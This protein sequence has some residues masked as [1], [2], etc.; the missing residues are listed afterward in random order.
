M[1]SP[2]ERWQLASAHFERLADAGSQ[3]K[4]AALAELERS[5]PDL[6]Q[7]LAQMLHGDTT[8]EGLLDGGLRRIAPTVVE[9]LESAQTGQAA[10][11]ALPDI[12]GLRVIE[13]IGSG[14]MG[15]V[16]L[17]ERGSGEFAQ[18][19]ALKLL[20]AGVDSPA[21]RRRFSHER[22]ILAALEH[23]D[24]ARFIDGGV[25]ADGRPWFA[26]E[27]V[28]GESISEYARRHRLGLRQRVTLMVQVCRAVAYAQSRLVVHRDLK[29]SNIL[30]D[31]SGRPRLLDFGIAKLLEQEPGPEAETELRAMSPAYAAPEQLLDQPVSTATDV[32]ALGVVLHELITGCLPRAAAVSQEAALARAREDLRTAP[33]ARLREAAEEATVELGLDR[34][35]VFRLAREARGDLDLILLTALRADPRRRYDG[36]AALAEDLQRWL[37][38]RPI[39]ARPD[40]AG[41]RFRRFVGRH[42]LGVATAALVL[43]SLLA[44]LSAALWQARRADAEAMRAT[45]AAERAERSR[46]FFA[47]LF[48]DASPVRQNKGAQMSLAEFVAEAAQRVETELVD[49][50]EEQAQIGLGLAFTLGDLGDRATALD[51]TEAAVERLR[52]LYPQGSASLAGGLQQRASMLND[53]GRPAEAEPDAR[54]ALAMFQ[55]LAEPHLMQQISVRTTLL[56]IAR[57]LGR[58][59]QLVEQSE[60]VLRDRAA[61]LG[62]DAAALAVDWY[63]LGIAYALA[64]RN[65]E[66]LPAYQRAEVLLASDPKAPQSRRAWILNAIAGSQRL[67]GDF[68]SAAATL[69]EAR[70]VA[71][72][73]MGPTHPMVAHALMG[74]GLVSHDAGD[75]AAAERQLREAQAIAAAGGHEVE[76][77]IQGEL[78]NLLI[79]ADAGREAAEVLQQASRALVERGPD[80]P[81]TLRTRSALA[82][83]LA[84]SGDPAAGL[85]ESGPALDSLFGLAIAPARYRAEAALNHAEVLSR[86]GRVEEAQVWRQRGEQ[87]LADAYGE[88]HP[89]RSALLASR[90]APGE[91]SP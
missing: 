41:Y 52:R 10:P 39:D 55:G 12:P 91:R 35:S 88:D 67:T 90:M 68:E 8:S 26:M 44:G 24:I 51:I 76:A 73:T 58:L 83:A 30:I 54:A 79:E 82:L 43:I 64:D 59:D 60:G 16:Y 36:A 71:E 47:R 1:R 27:L 4:Q 46:N 61:L 53:L 65:A 45:A 84:R 34:V 74:A 49:L 80:D 7:L 86:A 85:A 50:P 89:R 32:Y 18:R 11:A 23:P 17:A 31:A 20:R 2:A 28:Q 5:D 81:L 70:A 40:S 63:N 33:S 78:G 48:Q 9:D 29:P 56:A 22:R 62:D 42:R 77:R 87:A 57:Q 14:G 66:A 3:T 6:A 15:V 25:A 19:V 38:G 13:A 69:A 21:L 75:L 37:D 72:S